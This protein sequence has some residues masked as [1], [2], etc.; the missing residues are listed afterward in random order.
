MATVGSGFSARSR[1]VSVPPTIEPRVGLRKKSTWKIQKELC[2]GREL[3]QRL[4]P[5][6][7]LQREWNKLSFFHLLVVVFWVTCSIFLICKVDIIMTLT[8]LL[9]V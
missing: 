6:I 7:W 2:Q 9:E 5:M 3:S 1:Q 4:G 8:C